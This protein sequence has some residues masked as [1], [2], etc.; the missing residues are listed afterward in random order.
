MLDPIARIVQKDSVLV[1][2]L[3]LGMEKVKEIF[4]EDRYIVASQVRGDIPTFSVKKV[5]RLR[6]DLRA[7]RD[8]VIERNGKWYTVKSWYRDYKGLS[9]IADRIDDDELLLETEGG[10]YYAPSMAYLVLRSKNTE[11]ESQYLE[12]EIYLTADRRFRQIK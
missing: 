6:D 2:L 8:E 3:K 12:D 9:E 4:R 1:L 11:S 5:L 7:G 10:I